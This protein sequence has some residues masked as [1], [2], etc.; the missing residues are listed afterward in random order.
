MCHAQQSC[1]A[2]VAATATVKESAAM[3]M[4]NVVKDMENAGG[5]AVGTGAAA[6]GSPSYI[7]D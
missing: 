4:V 2:P 7:A 1:L 5:T 3:D 6:V